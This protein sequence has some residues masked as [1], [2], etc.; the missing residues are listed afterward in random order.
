MSVI[1]TKLLVWA[2]ATLLAILAWIGRMAV[3]HLSNISVSVNRIEKDLSVLANDHSNLKEEVKD[4]K[5]R[6]TKLELA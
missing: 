6:I 1:E 2:L 3:K 4:I 5:V